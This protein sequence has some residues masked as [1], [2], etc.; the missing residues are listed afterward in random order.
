MA[1]EITPWIKPDCALAMQVD[2]ITRREIFSREIN[3][4]YGEGGGLNANYRTVEAVAKTTAI[5]ASEGFRYNKHFV[6]KTG[7]GDWIQ[8]DFCDEE[9]KLG[10][11]EILRSRG[12]DAQILDT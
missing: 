11:K 3:E 6:F 7:T 8:F 1:H 5:L 10:A 4:R 12:V 9:T 2:T